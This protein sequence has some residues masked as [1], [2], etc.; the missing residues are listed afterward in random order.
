MAAEGTPIGRKKQL[1]DAWQ[2]ETDFTRRDAL[3]K[4][5][6]QEGL[7][8][9]KDP[10]FEMYPYD[11]DFLQEIDNPPEIGTLYPDLDSPDFIR[12]L[13]KKREF[14][15]NKYKSILDLEREKK[16]LETK[17][18]EKKINESE[19]QILKQFLDDKMNPCSPSLDFEP[20]PVQKFIRRFLSPNTPYLSALLFHGVGVGK[21]CAA[22]LTA[23]A[24]LEKHPNRKVIIVAPPNIQ[25]G[26]LRTIFPFD[27]VRYGKTPDEPNIVNGCTGNLYLTL[28][29][30]TYVR[31]ES[32]L[33][34]RITREI[35]RRYQIYGYLQF[36]NEI[37]KMLRTT[38]G[39]SLTK[40]KQKQRVNLFLRKRF[41]NRLLIIDEAHNL[42]DITGESMEENEDAPGGATEK[43]EASAGKR[44]TPLLKNILEQARG[45]KFMLL[46]ATPM[47]NSYKEII[48]L[49][50]LICR[51][52]KRAI[53]SE[54]HIF[55]ENGTFRPGGEELL[56]R[57][58]SCYISFMRGENPL[59]FPLRLEPLPTLRLTQW[60][61][62]SPQQKDVP[63]TD[64]SVLLN[65]PFVPCF[66][67]GETMEKYQ[68]LA[69]TLIGQSG[70]TLPVA[71]RIIQAGNWFFPGENQV[72]QEG[73]N[74]VFQE[75][76][77]SNLKRFTARGDPSWMLEEQVATV[78]PKAA[79][80]LE[81]A[82]GSRGVSF[83][84]SR[85][86]KSGALPMALVLEANGYTVFGRDAPL[87]TNGILD[88]SKGR[89][90]ARCSLREK[91]HI[92]TDHAFRPA[93]YALLTGS[94]DLSPNNVGVVGSERMPSNVLGEDIKI[95]LGS[96]VAS[97][98]IDLK[99][100]REIYVF[101]SWYH[102][103]KLE[104][105]LGRGIRM[106]S[107]A[108]LP[109]EKRNT[110]IYLLVSCF[111]PERSQE[112]LDL[113]Q[114]RIGMGK[115]KQIGEVSRVIKVNALDCN[116]NNPAT[117]IEGLESVTQIDAQGNTRTDV[118]PNDKDY[119]AMCDWLVCSGR[120]CKKPVKI[121]DNYL[122]QTDESTY[123][124]YAAKFYEYTIRK[125]I[126]AMFQEQPFYHFSDLED[127]GD[128]P[129]I[130][131]RTVMGEILDNR[132]F[133]IRQSSGQ[134]GYITFRNGYFLFQPLAIEDT[135][136]PLS[137]RTAPFMIRRDEY[138]PV[139]VSK[140]IEAPTEREVSRFSALEFLSNDKKPVLFQFW[141]SL[142]QWSDSISNRT[143][144]LETVPPEIL[145]HLERLHP[146]MD[147]SKKRA[148]ENTMDT[149]LFY[150]SMLIKYNPA[151]L[152]ILG[153]AI[154]E[155]FWDRELQ[156]N[157]QY[158][159]FQRK[160][161]THEPLWEEQRLTTDTRTIF[162]YVNP[163]HGDIVYICGNGECPASIRD[164]AEER[165]LLKDFQ[166]NTNT[167]GP[168]Y[169]T[170]NFKYGEFVFKTNNPKPP[171][172]KLAKGRECATISAVAVHY[173][174]IIEIAE[175]GRRVANVDLVVSPETIPPPPK[176]GEKGTKQGRHLENAVRNCVMKEIMLR[177]L[178]KLEKGKRRWF[179]RSVLTRLSGHEGMKRA[180][181]V[182]S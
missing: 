161:G 7:L 165:D 42:R 121:D 137:F 69:N 12:K 100:I 14:A 180:E 89:Q 84:Y 49:F 73:F 129:K 38:V 140:K 61:Q 23:E 65:L 133:L 94:E 97:E 113:Y 11:P 46:T 79:K 171:K 51:N 102:L 88:T 60:P 10:L 120:S 134:V 72:G 32:I 101:D 136:I 160:S 75:S 104:Q 8:P 152:P 103:N 147:L 130:A 5:M 19:Y 159:L 71:D 148:L 37:D 54:D 151:L 131:F 144:N 149:L 77:V 112:T 90:C 76:V 162:R 110:T 92:G 67:Q 132:Q 175:Q 80:V 114:Y 85:Y 106:C 55:E 83:L 3:L 164:E 68:E 13:L 172:A 41:S 169:G 44:L 48:F 145:F 126:K 105:V 150:S 91:Q 122:L 176:K 115:A 31:D 124:A 95:I 173:P 109:K 9:K 170:I 58:A 24:Y 177:M 168:T 179:L 29:E 99:F 45:L 125:R 86:I 107:H 82:K 81:L 26:F 15:E 157:E 128:I 74:S 141:D 43:S 118:N 57:L 156:W 119:T 56:G 20:S 146:G 52:E 135:G 93:K 64:Q 53:I 47:Y 39:S 153:A 33:R 138:K 6:E 155:I 1:L 40:E 139:L 59:S 166:A 158:A 16:D 35:N 63:S 111:P 154:P 163:F 62:K 116:L 167:C 21:T 36:Y 2:T 50:D 174:E 182:S 178:D 22:I 78:S 108:L 66:F 127:I 4:E 181:V 30:T 28:T 25:A 123:D 87:F 117:V 143:A 34:K 18:K 142:I 17:Y 70:I 27:D 96:Q 98:G